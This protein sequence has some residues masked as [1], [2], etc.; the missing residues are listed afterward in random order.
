MSIRDGP[1]VRG[2]GCI[3]GTAHRCGTLGCTVP[4]PDLLDFHKQPLAASV[5]DFSSGRSDVA[6]AAGLGCLMC[7]KTCMK[8]ARPRPLFLSF[9]FQEKRPVSFSQELKPFRAEI[10]EGDM[11]VR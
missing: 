8:L 9:P 2:C 10:K 4:A 11:A 6:V 3:P 5:T 1:P 7:S